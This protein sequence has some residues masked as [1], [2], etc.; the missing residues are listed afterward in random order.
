MLFDSRVFLVQLVC[1]LVTAVLFHLFLH[2]RKIENIITN[3]VPFTVAIAG[4]QVWATTSS[5]SSTIPV[6]V[7]ASLLIAYEI[8]KYLEKKRFRWEVFF[9]GFFFGMIFEF[10]WPFMVLWLFPNL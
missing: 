8:S 9:E 1:M 2:L 5:Q 6:H 10:S 4:A 7:I 3:Y